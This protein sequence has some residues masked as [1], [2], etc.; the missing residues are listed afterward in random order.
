MSGH[1]RPY[2]D[3]R[4][5]I[6]PEAGVHIGA[7]PIRHQNSVFLT[8]AHVRQPGQALGNAVACLQQLNQ[9][10]GNAVARLQQLNQGLKCCRM[11]ATAQPRPRKYCRTLATARQGPGFCSCTYATASG[12]GNSGG[13][14]PATTR[15]HCESSSKKHDTG[16]VARRNLL[17]TFASGY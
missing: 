15:T 11:L 16:C 1:G 13:R 12:R 5:F 4:A 8:V 9:G 10:L 7:K 3:A 14:T 6:C 17:C 2:A